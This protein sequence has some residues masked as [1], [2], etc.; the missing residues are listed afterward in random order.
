MERSSAREADFSCKQQSHYGEEN[1]QNEEHIRGA[2]HGVVRK[3]VRLA[4]HFI[5]IETYGEDQRRHAEQDHSSEG[6][7]A[8]VFGGLPAPV[9]CHQQPTCDREG[10]DAHDNEEECGDPLG[11]QPRRDTGA[12]P[13]MDGLT[14]SDKAH[15]E[16]T[17]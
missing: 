17:C 8:S 14:L 9:R 13:A 6:D 12:V 1:R 10:D 5:D 15:R 16:R 3:L 7:P 2:H 11:W 4:S